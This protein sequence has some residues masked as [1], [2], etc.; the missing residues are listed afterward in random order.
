M[1]SKE[2][3][4]E[5]R[6]LEEN[7]VKIEISGTAPGAEGRVVNAFTRDISLGG[8]RIMTDTDFPVGDEFKML[9]TLSKSKHIIK[10]RAVV[11]WSKQVDSGIFE[12]GIEFL[13]GVPAS[14]LTLIDHLYGKDREL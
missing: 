13:H 8:A 14:V 3:R 7:L 10:L 12:L 9:I 6:V 1:M 11:R 4:K 5:R 2:R